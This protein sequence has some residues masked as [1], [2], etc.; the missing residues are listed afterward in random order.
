MYRVPVS[1]S[2]P[3]QQLPTRQTRG[4]RSRKP[5][6]EARVRTK[7]L[8]G[9]VKRFLY[10]VV[11]K[12]IPQCHRFASHRDHK[13][14]HNAAEEMRETRNL[15]SFALWLSKSPCFSSTTPLHKT[16]SIHRIGWTRHE[17]GS[18]SFFDTTV[19]IS[20]CGNKIRWT[21]WYFRLLV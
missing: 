2:N 12:I 19:I 18:S 14:R 6:M 4:S 1:V 10:E 11:T 15:L 21:V 7:V 13:P 5:E 20:R 17:M 9:H 8:D 16:F 3:P